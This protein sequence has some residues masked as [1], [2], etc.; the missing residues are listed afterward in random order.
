MADT[1]PP[2]IVVVGS[3]LAGFGVLREL[4]RRSPEAK[5][6]LVTLEDGHFYSKPALSTAFAKGKTA[7]TLVTSDARK[8]ATQ[9][10]LDVRVGREAEAIDRTGKALLTTGGPVPYDSLILATGATPITPPIDGNAAHRAI[11][12][13][14]LD[15]YDRFRR[16]LPDGARVLVMGSGLVGTEFANDLVSHGYQPIVV[17]MLPLPLA[18]LVPPPV[19]EM[20]RDALAEKGVEW[21]LG[22][23]IISIEYKGDTPGYI[24]TLDDGTFIDSD[25]VLS[26]VGLRPNVRLA[27]E[28]G[29]DVGL[30]IKVNEFGQTSDPDIYA[31]GDC[32]EYRHGLSAFV[33][34]IMAAAR[35]I[36]PSALGEPTEIRFPPLSVQVKTTLMPINLLPPSRSVEGEWRVV[37]D[38]AQGTKHIFVDVDGI[39]RGYVLTKDKCEERMEMDAKVGEKV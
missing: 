25:L 8:I 26:A 34:P 39:M 37:E 20:V 7:E 38:D 15:H 31:I 36:A 21:H 1:S 33:T 2:S 11:A 19:G 16:E 4:R 27:Q 28:A 30:G 32:A 18:Q 17:D 5:L 12:I 6:T 10:K 3:G 24:A 14:Q 22:R 29:L 23:K 35:G 13:N 9:L